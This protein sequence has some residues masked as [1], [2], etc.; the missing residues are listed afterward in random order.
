MKKLALTLLIVPA[1]CLSSRAQTL[2]TADEVINKYFSA[3][4]GKKA[5]MKVKDVTSQGSL[6]FDNTPC[7]ITLLYKMPNKASTV[8]TG[9]NSQV[10]YKGVCDGTTMMMTAPQGTIRQ[11]GPA[12][13]LSSMFNRFV[14]E[15]SYQAEGI[16]STV[17]GIEPIDGR[18][19]YKVTSTFADGSPLWTNYY[20][21]ATGLKVQNVTKWDQNRTATLKTSDYRAVSGIKVPFSSSYQENGGGVNQ[22]LMKSVQINTGV[23]DT[24]FNVQ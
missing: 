13:R 24:E 22:T 16:K 20:D 11:T 14:A 3:I 12:A 2:P 10:L 5:L 21:V 9:N 17:E 4:G 23:S 1:L 15:L 6:Q 8:I 19:A 7:Q 18:D